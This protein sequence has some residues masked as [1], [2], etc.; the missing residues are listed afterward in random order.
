MDLEPL[1]RHALKSIGSIAV[2]MPVMVD[3][4][5]QVAGG[6]TLHGAKTS[7]VRDVRLK[8]LPT[9]RHRDMP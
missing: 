1:K 5:R 2:G 7:K 4:C 8:W 3:R 6:R 9:N